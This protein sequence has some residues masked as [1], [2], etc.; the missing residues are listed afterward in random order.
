MNLSIA[1][2][3]VQPFYFT[4]DQPKGLQQATNNATVSQKIEYSAGPYPIRDQLKA[5][6]D[7]SMLLSKL[8]ESTINALVS[9]YDQKRGAMACVSKCVFQGDGASIVTEFVPRDNRLTFTYMS[10]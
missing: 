2:T 4:K 7:V 9:Y 10:P 8:A 6:G 3:T 1:T 5:G